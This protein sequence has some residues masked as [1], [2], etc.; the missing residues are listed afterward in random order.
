MVKHGLNGGRLWRRIGG[1]VT[2]S[3]LVMC[4]LVAALPG[5]AV[6]KGVTITAGTSSTVNCSITAKGKLSP[7]LKYDWVQADHSGDRVAAVAAMANTTFGPD[8]PITTTVKGTGTCTGSVTDRTNTASVTAI[9]FTVTN[10]PSAPG[11]TTEQ[12]CDSLTAGSSETG[13]QYDTTITY[14]ATGAKVTPTEVTGQ[15]LAPFTFTLS[16]GT[17]TG[18]FAGQPETTSGQLD[19]TTTAAIAQ[20]APTSASPN[21]TYP[22]CQP[23]LKVKAPYKTGTTTTSLKPPKGLKRSRS[24]PARPW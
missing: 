17:T 5:V 1:A 2:G 10:D 20:A 14:V 8:G 18:S 23:T 22:Q 24:S 13:A 21:P 15:T 19:A 12:T 16:G 6:A 9:K 3:A 4:A 11:N 7:P